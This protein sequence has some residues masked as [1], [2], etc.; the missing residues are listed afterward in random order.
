MTIS[1][2][3]NLFALFVEAADRLQGDKSEVAVAAE[4]LAA[5]Q[6]KLDKETGDVG[7][8]EIGIREATAALVGGITAFVETELGVALA[9]A[10]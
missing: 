5:A 9:P 10:D 1:E 7:G 4:A 2:L 3:Q 8:A 6:A